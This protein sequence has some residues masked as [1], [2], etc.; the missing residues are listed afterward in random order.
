MTWTQLSQLPLPP[1]GERIAYGKLPQQFGELRVPRGPGPFPVFV[2]V[3]G[4]CWMAEFDYVY[5]T[6]LSA[7]LVER[8]FATWT[9]EFRRVG[10]EGGGWPGTFLDVA[11]ATDHLREIA[12]SHP[13]DL[14]RV[15]AAGHSAGGE[16]ALWLPI[17]A[18][19][20]AAS[21][22]SRENPL[23]I[24]GVL[25]LAA[26]TDLRQYRIGPADSCHGSVDQ[27]L[28]G[29]PARYPV[30]YAETSPRQR[31]PLRVPQAFVQGE[32]DPIVEPGPVRAYV[33]AAE[34]SGDRARIF[35]L[36]GAGHF[37][38]SVPLRG[39]ERTFDEALRFLK[40]GR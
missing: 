30:R 25:G 16:L 5:M 37:E 27:L 39:T 6:R 24:R 40:A 9:I 33:A 1:R 3:H 2:I 13:L 36:P 31:L 29:S 8:G 22:L 21:A 12:R 38:A 15:Y 28:G 7:W 11:R 18:R 19:L 35:L 34:Q 23:P 4:G 32:A 10:N 17:R 26:V 20:P 14:E